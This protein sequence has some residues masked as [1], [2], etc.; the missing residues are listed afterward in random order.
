MCIR[1]ARKKGVMMNKVIS[2]EL[3]KQQLNRKQLNHIALSKQA[4]TMGNNR[5]DTLWCAVFNTK[6]P[7][8]EVAKIYDAMEV[9]FNKGDHTTLGA[10]NDKSRFAD[11]G[12]IIHGVGIKYRG[13]WL[14]RPTY[15]LPVA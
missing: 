6:L 7:E 15:Y 8:D 12:V 1:Y 9:P 5:A 10:I 2:L 3:N 4:E 13:K 11:Q 14:V